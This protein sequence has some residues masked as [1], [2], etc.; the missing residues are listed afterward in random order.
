M[1]EFNVISYMFSK[2]NS[3]E[4]QK[5]KKEKKKQWKKGRM[6]K[7]KIKVKINRN[8]HFLLPFIHF[9]TSLPLLLSTKLL[10]TY[11]SLP[12]L[13][14]LRFQCSYYSLTCDC[15]GLRACQQWYGRAH[16]AKRGLSKEMGDR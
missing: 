3:K 10:L 12:S 8:R 5:T 15:L 11:L 1:K 6:E 13:S 7:W 2:V 4:K 16:G 9:F 14:L